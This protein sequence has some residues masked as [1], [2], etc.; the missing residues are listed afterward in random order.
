MLG[1]FFY[2]FINTGC[3]CRQTIPNNPQRKSSVFIQLC[4]MTVLMLPC[5]AFIIAHNVLKE[6]DTH[7]RKLLQVRVFGL[8]TV[9]EN[10]KIIPAGLSDYICMDWSRRLAAS[11]PVCRQPAC[12]C[13]CWVCWGGGYGGFC[14]ALML[15]RTQKQW[16]LH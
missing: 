4:L 3:Q 6:L 10:L 15:C 9:C 1:D 13:G 7:G 2:C 11:R 5:V 8:H 14:M 16:H 12:L